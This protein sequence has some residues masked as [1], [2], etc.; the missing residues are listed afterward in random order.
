MYSQ[1]IYLEEQERGR[2]T[3]IASL[4]PGV[5]DTAMQESIRSSNQEDF[6][7]R[8][9][10]LDFHQ[11]MGLKKPKDVAQGILTYIAHNQFDITV[12][13]LP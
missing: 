12:N 11:N 4:S 9:R 13:Q 8:Q 3:R 2:T 1:T 7:N 5:V 6:S 10:F